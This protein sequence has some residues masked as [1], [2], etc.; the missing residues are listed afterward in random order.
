[1]N[2]IEI[3]EKVIFETLKMIKDEDFVLI[4]GYAVNAYTL[5]QF[6]VDCDIVVKDEKSVSAIKKKMEIAGYTKT[7]EDSRKTPYYGSFVRYEKQIEK[8]FTV[9]MDILIHAVLD[10]GT[11]GAFEAS[12]VFANAKKNILRGKTITEK[13]ELRIVRLDALI[14]M[15]CVP[16]HLTDIRDIFMLIVFAEDLG[17]IRNEVQQRTN[18]SEKAKIISEKINSPSFKNNLQGVYGY[19]EDKIF[20]KHK[21]KVLE[22]CK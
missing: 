21:K 9:S 6:S 15:K 16:C 7:E 10:R 11:Q 5:P 1:M 18:F 20:E 3:R 17:W 14:A 4:G 19:I 22:F 12:W 8:N 13:V 2:P